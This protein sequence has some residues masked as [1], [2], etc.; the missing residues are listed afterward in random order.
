M[1]VIKMMFRMNKIKS[2]ISN[3]TT[4]D[5]V[6]RYLSQ[7]KINDNTT[8]NLFSKLKTIFTKC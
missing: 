1:T 2:I 3:T 5:S 6:K 7:S 4:I 8:T